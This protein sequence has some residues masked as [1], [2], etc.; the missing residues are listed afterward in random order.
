MAQL[1]GLIGYPLSHSF[2][3]RYFAGKFADEGLT[4]CRYELFPLQRIDELPALLAAHGDL[5]GLNVTIPYKEKVLEYLD[6]LDPAA[7]EIGAVNVIQIRN[8][9]LKGYNSDALGFDESLS[10]WLPAGEMRALVLGSGGASKAVC[11]ALRKRKIAYRL[12]S[13]RPQGGE[14][15]YEQLNAGL[16]AEHRLI[17]NTTPLGMQPEVSSCPPIPYSFLEAKHYLYDLVYNP[18]ET[19]FL[20]LGAARACQTKNG[21]EMLYRQAEKAWQIWQSAL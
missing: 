6:E 14:L 8:G 1:Y 13:R 19:T 5:I 18:E 3:Q 17:V 9:Y 7:A 2:S 20:K 4:A 21:L 11:W 15:S 12:V 16:L 10:G